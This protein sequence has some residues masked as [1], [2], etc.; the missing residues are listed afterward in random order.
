MALVWVLVVFCDT[1]SS[2]LISRADKVPRSS[3]ST[4][5]SRPVSG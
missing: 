1:K 3:R 4:A 2:W 5:I